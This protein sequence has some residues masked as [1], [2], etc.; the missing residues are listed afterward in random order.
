MFMSA[1]EKKPGPP[2]GQVIGIIT[3]VTILRNGIK[4][5]AYNP[6]LLNAMLDELRLMLIGEPTPPERSPEVRKYLEGA[7]RALNKKS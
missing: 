1:P 2:K 5:L 4:S 6:T 7:L 3:T